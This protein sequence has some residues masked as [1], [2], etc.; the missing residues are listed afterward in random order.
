MNTS[1]SAAL[2][3]A[4]ALYT[5]SSSVHSGDEEEAGERWL[6]G[7]H[8]IHSRYSVTYARSPGVTA[9]QTGP[10]HVKIT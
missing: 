1:A 5:L 7:D 6:A 2:I 10:A 8:H 4:I 9:G 3:A